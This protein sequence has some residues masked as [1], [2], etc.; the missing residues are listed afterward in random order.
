[1][2]SAP[3]FIIPLFLL[4]SCGNGG[5]PPGRQ[6][7]FGAERQ[8]LFSQRRPLDSLLA[9][10][11]EELA[12]WDSF[13][14]SCRQEL[15]APGLPEEERQALSRAMEEAA[16]RIQQYRHDPST[17]NL[18]GALKQVLA[19]KQAPL[20]RRLKAIKMQMEQAPRYYG[21]AKANIHAPIPERCR[22]AAEKQRLTLDF[23]SNELQDSLGRLERN[24]AEARQFQATVEK[25]RIA[26]K[27]YLAFCESLYFEHQDSLINRPGF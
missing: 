17:Y 20:A 8:L 27:D 4:S 1:M 16:A 24:E 6:E 9:I 18:G 7:E 23:L 21:Y 5:G 11:P 3:W 26:V 22:L 14:R 19:A 15:S 12:R 13:Y 25:A 2:R 10:G